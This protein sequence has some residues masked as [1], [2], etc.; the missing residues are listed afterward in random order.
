VPAM[1]RA[2]APGAI[3][4]PR[5]AERAIMRSH[6]RIKQDGRAIRRTVLAIIKSLSTPSLVRP[7][8][9]SGPQLVDDSRARTLARPLRLARQSPITSPGW[10]KPLRGRGSVDLTG[11]A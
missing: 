8:T 3:E 4:S 5:Y 9:S 10:T 6:D 7:L 11:E 1:A 2:I